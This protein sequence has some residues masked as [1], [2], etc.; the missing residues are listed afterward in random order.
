MEIIKTIYFNF[1][2]RCASYIK[3]KITYYSWVLGT[4]LQDARSNWDYFADYLSVQWISIGSI[5]IC[6]EGE[7]SFHMNFLKTVLPSLIPPLTWSLSLLSILRNS[8][9][10]LVNISSA[11]FCFCFYI[12][13]SLTSTY[14]KRA[15]NLYV[16]QWR[17][18]RILFVCMSHT[19][20]R[21]PMKSILRMDS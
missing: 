20:P 4:W 1:S 17:E 21:K 7:C 16:L 6:T 9:S 3:D 2:P 11:W 15:S 12:M 8:Y 13:T 18:T 19:T 5:V 10:A 14:P